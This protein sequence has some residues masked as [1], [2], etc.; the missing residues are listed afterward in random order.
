MKLNKV[1][2][3]NKQEIVNKFNEYFVDIGPALAKKIPPPSDSYDSFLKS[4]YKNSFALFLTNAEEIVSIVSNMAA[5]KSAGFDN[6]S[7]EIMKLSMPYI[8]EPLSCLIN[9]SLN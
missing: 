9:K 5:K 7:V 1:T 3:S 2:I 8:A 6:I 4:K